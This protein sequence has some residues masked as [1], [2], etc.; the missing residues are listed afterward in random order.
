MG[1]KQEVQE[2]EQ[3]RAMAQVGKQQLQDFKN[4]WLPLQRRLMGKIA[5]SGD[6]NSFQARRATTM[7]GVDTG[8]QFGQARAKLD[9]QAAGAGGGVQGSAYKLGV[10]GLDTDA[11]TS[12]ALS[13]VAAEQGVADQYTHG[14][15]A[16]TAMGRG[17]K[18]MAIS[19]MAQQAQASG[20]QAQVDAQHALEDRAG[21]MALASKA[22]GTGAYLYGTQPAADP[23]LNSTGDP[24]V[25]QTNLNGSLYT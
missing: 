1:K 25:N 21:N 14:L 18:T 15:Q 12:G 19:G 9:E 4:R 5:D 7:A 16:V 3:Q 10:M 17:E 2:T 8:V 6:P 11:A 23:G 22:I 24:R 20:Q 13:G